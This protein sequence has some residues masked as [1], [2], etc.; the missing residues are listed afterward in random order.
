MLADLN[1]VVLKP[2]D[3]DDTDLADRYRRQLQFTKEFIVRKDVV[4]AWLRFLK[5]NHPGYRNV[6]INYQ[7]DLLHNAN[8]I[9]QVANSRY[10]N[11]GPSRDAA[12]DQRLYTQLEANLANSAEEEE[13]TIAE[14][15]RFDSSTIPAI[16]A[17]RD[18]DNNLDN[19]RR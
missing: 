9:D 15:N 10:N 6:Q 5:A 8:V 3:A 14:D 1:V 13:D 16:N 2:A 11:N 4:L 12:G 18:I 17:D 19:L 7:I